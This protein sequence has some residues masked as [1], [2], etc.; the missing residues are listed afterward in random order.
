MAKLEKINFGYPR[1]TLQSNYDVDEMTALEL[2]ARTAKKVDECVEL[3]NGVEQ[4]AIEA[5]VIVDAM[6]INQEQ[7]I[8]EN[9][10]VRQNLVTDNEDFIAS[11][12]IAK[13]V[14]EGD[15][16]EELNIFKN[17]LNASK[18]LFETTMTND[19]TTIETLI[20]DAE[21]SITIFETNSTTALSTFNANGS[22]AITVFNASIDGIVETEV[23]Q[24]I[25]TMKNDGSLSDLIEDLVT[26]VSLK[27]DRLNIVNVKDFGAV[28]NG[29]TNDTVAIQNALNAVIGGGVVYFPQGEYKITAT[30]EINKGLTIQG[31]GQYT[32]LITA[33]SCDAIRIN[34]VNSVKIADIEIA[35]SVRHSIAA[36][37]FVGIY[38]DGDTTYRPFNHIYH[39]IYIDGF[40]T[41]ILTKW[42]WSSLFD[43]FECN[44]GL[45]GIS[46]YG[47]SVNNVVTKSSISTTGLSSSRGIWFTGDTPSEGWIISDTLIY[48]TEIAIHGIAMTH[49]NIVNCILDFCNVYAIYIQNSATNFG[50]NWNISNNYIAMGGAG[51]D[52]AI[53]SDN[54]KVDPQNTGNRISNN[55]VLVYA[56]KSCLKGVN[57]SGVECKNNVVANNTFKGFSTYDIYAAYSDNVINGN[58]CLSAITYNINAPGIVTNNKG[59]VYYRRGTNFMN[60]GQIAINYD[61]AIPTA[62]GNRG[63]LCINITPSL[64]TN[65]MWQC[66][67]SGAAGVAQWQPFGIV[68]AIKMTAQVDSTAVD[69]ATLKADFNALLAKLRVAK[70][71]P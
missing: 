20:V 46:A 14:F 52:S 7:F 27:V 38:V 56:G 69:V 11:L 26:P 9:A 47:L 70:L 42:L 1:G 3:V 51:G 5:T 68:G 24:T 31:Q 25:V 23:S 34:K 30:L 55:Y 12:D 57:M 17:G 49:V 40:Q 53:C 37:A 71:M 28:G 39:N 65:S 45:R 54:T 18:S 13:V 50:G 33:F 4:S 67:V 16:T 10:D 63:D 66:T 58:E 19:L 36:N 44:F 15:L 43:N 61:E 2:A 60:V 59:S 6:E 64:G 32:T 35:Q 22:N 29:S 41:A 48:N 8:L 21:N 62:A